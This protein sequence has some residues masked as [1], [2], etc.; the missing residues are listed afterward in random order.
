MPAVRSSLAATQEQSV[1]I[2]NSFKSHCDAKRV[3]TKTTV[4]TLLRNAYEHYHVTEVDARRI[5]LFDFASTDK[6]F[7]TLDSDDEH[8]NA[9]RNWSSIGEGIEKKM[10]PGALTDDFHF[11]R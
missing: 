2:F 5:A 6:A 3:D 4:L 11:A 7:L 10:H 9:T 1:S 8:F